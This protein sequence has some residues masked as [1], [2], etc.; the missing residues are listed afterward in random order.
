VP[1]HRPG[2]R[3]G[4]RAAAREEALRRA[5]Q[6][7][8][9]FVQSCALR[10]IDEASLC[11]LQ[12]AGRPIR[13]SARSRPCGR[14]AGAG[15]P[16]A[17]CQRLPFGTEF[18][19]ALLSTSRMSLGWREKVDV[20][21]RDGLK[22]WLHG[23]TGGIEEVPPPGVSAA[24]SL[25]Q[26]AWET[27]AEFDDDRV[28]KARAERQRTIERLQNDYRLK[29][30]ERNRRVAEYNRPR[31]QREAGLKD[32]RRE[33][34]MAAARILAPAVGVT[35]A[36]LD[37]QSGALGRGRAGGGHRGRHD[38]RLHRHA[39]GL[40]PRRAHRSEE[41]ALAG[42]V[43][44]GRCGGG[45]HPLAAD[46]GR[47]AQHARRAGLAGGG[48]AG[49]GGLGD[50][51]A[52]V[53]RR[54]SRPR[55]PSR[56][57]ATRSSQILYREENETLRRR[58]EEQRRQ[59]EQAGG[60][61]RG[62]RGRGHRAA[63]A[64]TEALRNQP[65][66]ARPYRPG[67]GHRARGACAGDRQLPPTRAAAGWP[68]RSTMRVP[69]ARRLRALGFRVADVSLATPR[70]TSLVRGLSEFSRMPAQADLTLLFY[71][72]HGAADAAA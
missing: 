8:E 53:G 64:E 41:P 57:T 56:S 59:Q 19:N 40:P 60:Q 15:F 1:L 17:S 25:R 31:Q 21:V 61:R 27:H 28:T 12:S 67:P 69:M 32:A 24:L 10:G 39:A 14:W 23:Q 46:R 42:G 37:Q 66:P 72:G 18:F 55:A 34:T 54:R 47:R 9:E 38:L 48:S 65:A 44:R 30:E 2:R 62:A 33:M 50:P 68:T 22:D 70:G 52:G 35:Q 43:G 29:V 5:N 63:R 71:A 3:A 45:V 58:L 51:A 11:L 6:R 49:A 13:R 16:P 7:A 20:A 36:S 26:E 4:L